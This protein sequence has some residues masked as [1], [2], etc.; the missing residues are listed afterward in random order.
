MPGRASL[1]RRDFLRAG[2]ATVGAAAAAVTVGPAGTAPAD[3]TPPSAAFRHGVASGDPLPDAVL[4]WTR[5]TPTPDARPGSGRGPRATLRWEVAR[6]AQFTSVVR[7]G[8]ATTTAARDHTLTVDVTGL[9]PATRYYYRFT[10]AA[11][12]SAGQRSPIGRTTTA[13]AADADNDSL[14]LGV[15]SCANYEAGWFTA[16]RRLAERDDVDAVVELGDY[17]YEYGRG[18]YTGPAGLIRQAEPAHLVV[19]LNDYRQRMAT[20]HADPDLQEAHRRFPWICTWDDHEFTDNSYAAGTTGDTPHNPRRY[21]SWAARKRAAI[22]AYTEWLPIRWSGDLDNPTIYRT[23]RFGR[24]AD[25]SMLDLRTYRTAQPDMFSPRIDSPAATI[26]GKTQLDWLIHQLTTSS[27]RWQLVGNSVMIAPVLLPPLDPRITGALTDQLGINREGPTFNTD[28]WDGYSR[29]RAALFSALARRG[30]RNPVFL[31]GDIHSSWASNLTVN[32]GDRAARS[33]GVEFVGPSVTSASMSETVGVP[34]R[35]VA[36]IAEQAVAAV[37]P[38]IRWTHLDQH[39]YMVVRIGRARTVTQW[40][41]LDTV[42]T[43]G[44]RTRVAATWQVRD[45]VR[46]LERW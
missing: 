19:H 10:S 2:A 33:V 7:S 40:H 6:D 4:I 27:A 44:G 45:G 21:G 37:N 9:A 20:H 16:Y 32:A 39:G 24:L 8:S 3:P 36:P 43:T 26:T 14:V 17:I 25:L 38:H 28:Q 34:D 22:Q 35:T 12:P 18:A 41:L 11:G 42:V 30:V 5:I 15:V 13:P 31:T 1:D 23:L 29:D 46:R